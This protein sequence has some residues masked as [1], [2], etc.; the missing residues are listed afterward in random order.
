M[1]EENNQGELQGTSAS[2]MDMEVVN[3]SD[4]HQ[5]LDQEKNDQDELQNTSA[6]EDLGVD[7]EK[8]YDVFYS[9][10]EGSPVVWY[11]GYRD[12]KGEMKNKAWE[13]I[14]MRL[15]E[16]FPIEALEKMSMGSVDKLRKKFKN[17]RC[18]R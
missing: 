3:D 15:C 9:L 1:K 7:Q 5:E 14:L 12:S 2:A 16:I 6:T 8:V 4:G 18:H 13:E 10:I 11:P 17:K